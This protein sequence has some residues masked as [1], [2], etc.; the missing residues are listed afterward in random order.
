MLRQRKNKRKQQSA[1]P[2]A[3][4]PDKI[5]HGFTLKGYHWA[6]AMLEGERV[7]GGVMGRSKVIENRHFRI[8]PGWYGVVVGKG[9]GRKEDY[10]MVRRT[11]PTMAIP[12]W[13]SQQAK[14]LRGKVVGVVQITHSMK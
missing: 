3:A 11:L 1:G 10:E 9:T 4:T 12:A 7:S 2:G 5:T 6:Y 13:E 14:Q 8:T